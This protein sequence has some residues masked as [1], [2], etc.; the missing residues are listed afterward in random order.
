[1]L[2][3]VLGL[4]A[5]GA[6]LR[7]VP[8]SPFASKQT[9]TITTPEVVEPTPT[10]VPLPFR[11]ADITVAGANTAGFLSWSLLDRRSGEIV[12]SQNM[13]ETTTTASMIKA[14]LAA[15]YLRRA[16]ETGE[17]PTNSRLNDLEVMIRDSNNEAADR[18]YTA[19]GKAAS[20]ER[21]ISICG[22]TDSSAVPGFWSNTNISAEDTVRMGE[23]IA[24][25]RAAGETWTPWVLDMMRKVR[26][27]GDFGIRK[28]FPTDQQANV[29][30]KNGWLLRDEDNNWHTNC[31]AIGDSWVLAVLQQYPSTGDWNTDFAHTTEVC[32]NVA[33]LLLNPEAS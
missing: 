20:I 33:T 24:D 5:V 17:T 4:G 29:A 21:L 18:T 15:D 6:G 3:L 8:G 12:G 32:Q 26:D 30:I 7:L 1:M 22:L 31:L 27:V 11:S 19:N 14:W 13:A 16:S 2:L 10:P 23:C 25:G 9:T 28:A